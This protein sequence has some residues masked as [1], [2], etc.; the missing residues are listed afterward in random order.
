MLVEQLKEHIFKESIYC[1]CE[2]QYQISA[3]QPF[4]NFHVE[5]RF[6]P[7]VGVIVDSGYQG[8]SNT[9]SINSA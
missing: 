6:P 1:I 7:M 8:I 4:E 5:N 2:N 9:H 3:F